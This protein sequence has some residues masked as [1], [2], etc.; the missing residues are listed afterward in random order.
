MCYKTTILHVLASAKSDED[1]KKRGG[2]AL[3]FQECFSQFKRNSIFAILDRVRGSEA[4]RVIIDFL[5]KP[6]FWDYPLRA[7]TG[8]SIGSISAV[9]RYAGSQ[10]VIKRLFSAN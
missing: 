6:K 10:N 1:L 2:L 7:W 5:T 9:D 3:P 4:V 8:V